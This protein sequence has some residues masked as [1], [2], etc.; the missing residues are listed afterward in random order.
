M[1]PA[2]FDYARPQSLS[3][4]LK[5]LAIHGDNAKIIA[6]GQSLVPMM[7]F[8]ISRPELLI[9]I[10]K[11]PDLD[12]H[13]CSSDGHYLKIGAL[14]R[15][16]TL[17]NSALIAQYCPLM[18]KAYQHVAHVVVRNR[19]TL[20]GNLAHAD[21]ASEMPAVMLAL[22][23]TMVIRSN[24]GE[25]KVQAEDFFNGLYSTDIKKDEILVE[26]QIPILDESFRFGFAE[27]SPRKGDYAS[28]LVAV[29]FKLIKGKIE[30]AALSYA[31][32]SD[33]P[34]RAPAAEKALLGQEPSSDLFQ[35]VSTIVVQEIYLKKE[36][37]ES[38]VFQADLI[39]TLTPRALLNAIASHDQ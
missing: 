1:K 6:G 28:T 21:P 11:I 7:N 18:H 36:D 23:A 10:N 13:E 8:R 2:S 25:R 24:Q 14:A 16:E 20:C 22:D 19:G 38:H 4:A 3:D 33:R 34:V 5:L 27:L 12:Y 15:H 32:I 39:Q 9:D 17:R 29:M 30:S 26:V 31:G 37:L 35:K